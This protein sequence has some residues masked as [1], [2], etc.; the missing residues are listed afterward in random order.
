MKLPEVATL[1][2]A[3]FDLCLF[4]VEFV[5]T[6]SKLL[7]SIGLQNFRNPF[8]VSSFE[9]C[10]EPLTPPMA[11]KIRGWIDECT[12]HH[13]HCIDYTINKA[14]VPKRLINLKGRCRLESAKSPV[15]YAA[16][17]YCWGPIEQPSTTKSNVALRYNSFQYRELPQTLQDAILMTR[18]LGLDYLW[19]DAICI[20]QDDKEEW[21][22]EAARMG[23]IY[24]MAHVVLVATAANNATEGFLRPRDRLQKITSLVDPE[25]PITINA[26]VVDTHDKDNRDTRLEKQPLSKRGWALQEKALAGRTVHFL[27]DEALFQC[28][29]SVICECGHYSH[30]QVYRLN[31]PVIK[32]KSSRSWDDFSAVGW[33]SLVVDFTKRSLTQADD[34]LPALSGIAQSK[35][36]LYPGRYFAGIWERDIAHQLGWYVKPHQLVTGDRKRKPQPRPTFSWATFP[37]PISCDFLYRSHCAFHSG[38]AVPLAGDMYGQV[39]EA[40]IQMRGQTMSGWDLVGVIEDLDDTLDDYSRAHLTVHIDGMHSIPLDPFLKDLMENSYEGLETACDWDTVLCFVLGEDFDKK[41]CMLI[42]QEVAG[43]DAFERIGVVK[44]F[45]KYAMDKLGP[46]RIVTIV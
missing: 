16:L 11:S 28:R 30:A 46:E 32:R 41:I 40:V 13:N 7:T 26:R 14:F 5:K 4:P 21:A 17:S 27:R 22:G 8:P 6:V 9:I 20:V 24:S 35:L 37:G 19:I 33:M 12:E 2:L 45:P 29:S 15:R 23:E 36:P 3:D 39:K 42:L 31:E 44:R 25:N 43:E 1:S 34:A 10:P 38:N 18:M